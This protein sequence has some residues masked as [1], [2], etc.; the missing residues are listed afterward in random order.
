[1]KWVDSRPPRAM[2]RLFC[3]L[4]ILGTG[5]VAFAADDWPQWMGATRDGVWRE[6]GLVERFPEDGPR[7]VWRVPAGAGYAGPAVADG[8]VFIMEREGRPTEDTSKG[9]L[10]V[11]RLRALDPAT[12]K[13]LWQKEWEAPY[14]IDYATGPR[15]TPTVHDGLVYALGAEGRLVCVRAQDG[16]SVWERDLKT[17]F[18]CTSPTWG[19]AGHPLVWN[20]LLLCLVGGQGTTA[21]A[22]DRR[23]GAEKWRALSSSQAGYCPPTLISNRGRDEVIIWH[24]EAINSLDPATGAVHWTMPKS[25]RFGVSMAMPRQVGDDL[26][27]SAFWWGSR[28]MRLR[29]DQS[30]PEIV[31]ETERESDTRTEHLNA[32]MCTPLHHDGFLYGVCSYGQ[33]RCLEWSSGARKWETFAAT[34]GTG[35]ERWGTA[36]LTRLAGPDEDGQRFLLFNEKG[37]LILARLTPE[38]YEEISRAAIVKPDCPAVKDRPV[39]WTHPAYAG[40]RAF[41]KNNTEVVCVDLAR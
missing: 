8:R 23:T 12:G 14:L 1:M 35:E 30:E 27:V 25:T 19:F 37:E 3:L 11:E 39:V 6:S 38:K 40:R 28:M 7:V 21:V 32:L 20:D 10:G 2:T 16:S 41:I 34:T 24:G 33:L 26:L 4:M 13:T 9:L 17:D 15:A 31:W 36:F 22:L 18:Q 29:E 5:A